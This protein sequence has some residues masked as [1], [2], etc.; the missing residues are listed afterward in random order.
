MKRSVVAAFVAVSLSFVAISGF[1]ADFPSH[2]D[3]RLT[4]GDVCHNPDT[5]RY[6]EHVAYCSRA[7][8]TDFKK[9]IIVQYD[10][11]LGFHVGAMSRSLFKIDHYIPLCAG[12]SNERDNLWPQHVSIY[13]ITDPV[14]PLICQKMAAGRLKQAQAIDIIKRAKANLDQVPAIIDQLEKM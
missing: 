10:R 6:P 2:P 5:Y 13:S 1:A 3:A 8:D 11:E 4:P 12:G 9:E 14:E 7:V